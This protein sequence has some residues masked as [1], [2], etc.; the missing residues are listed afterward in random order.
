MNNYAYLFE[1]WNHNSG[2][3]IFRVYVEQSNIQVL[4]LGTQEN[5]FDTAQRV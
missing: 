4:E 1:W 5:Q 3:I 2:F